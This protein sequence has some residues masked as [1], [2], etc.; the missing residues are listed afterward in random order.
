MPLWH[1]RRPVETEPEA[2]LDRKGRR[3][4]R[5]DIPAA[6]WLRYEATYRAD[7]ARIADR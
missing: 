6:S 4:A 1:N 3:D 7:L 5:R 2:S